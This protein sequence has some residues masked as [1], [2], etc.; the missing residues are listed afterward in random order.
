MSS[1]NA[2]VTVFGSS[3]VPAFDRSPVLEADV[4]LQELTTR[5]HLFPHKSLEEVLAETRACP[6]AAQR[7]KEW[8]G[9]DGTR[10]IGRVKRAELIQLANSLHRFW[11]RAMA[12]DPASS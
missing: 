2:D 7:A 3:A 8:L 11:K 9:L 12:S 1:E 10:P 6:V 5:Q 4:I